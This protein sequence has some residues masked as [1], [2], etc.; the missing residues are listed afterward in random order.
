MLIVIGWIGSAGAIAGLLAAV[1]TGAAA[2]LLRKQP[3]TLAI[4]LVAALAL[5]QGTL[6]V[7]AMRA[8]TLYHT[9]EQRGGKVK[10]MAVRLNYWEGA[11]RVF[12]QHPLAGVGAG[13][14][15]KYYTAFKP[16]YASEDVYHPHNWL[17]NQ[18]AEWGLLGIVGLL[19]A[20]GG[21]GWRI[22]RSLAQPVD[23]TDRSP[24][25][26]LLFA[27]LIV[28]GCWTMAMAGGWASD[29][30]IPIAITLTALGP[31]QPRASIQPGRAGDLAGRSDRIPGTCNGGDVLRRGW[32]TLALLGDGTIGDDMG[33]FRGGSRA[34]RETPPC[35]A[36]LDIA[37]RRRTAGDCADDP[38]IALDRPDGPGAA[39]NAGAASRTG[40]PAP[41]RSSRG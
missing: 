13:Q 39:G 28:L 41:R 4:V 9:L 37:H 5:M 17:L 11:I 30:W 6:V 18:G 21:P 15:G 12:E 38:A 35:A 14:F 24:A 20:L 33:I 31:C 3:K 25:D 26:S 2:W 22:L 10:S 29:P 34:R 8:G 27:A 19:V 16:P 36:R 1:A 40:S 7:L 32:G 23:E